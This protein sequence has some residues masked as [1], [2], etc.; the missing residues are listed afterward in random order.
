[1]DFKAR[2]LAMRGKRKKTGSGPVS[3]PVM[4]AA[5]PAP[6]E[7][8]APSQPAASSE[9]PLERAPSAPFAVQEVTPMVEEDADPTQ[10]EP[11]PAVRLDPSLDPSSDVLV[12]S[13]DL[14]P[15]SEP[16]APPAPPAVDPAP[17]LAAPPVSSQPEAPARLGRAEQLQQWLG[18]IR[19]RRR[20]RASLSLH[21]ASLTGAAAPD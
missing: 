14:S 13:V 5:A 4:P 8:P 6:S 12:D 16:P 1:M 9:P 10:F 19:E 20:P 7:P 17:V 15:A 11:A 2:M 3:S 18:R 21:R